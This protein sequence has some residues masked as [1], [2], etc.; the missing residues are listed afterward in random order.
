M[1][2]E[3]VLS[4]GRHDLGAFFAWQPDRDLV[5]RHVRVTPA[6]SRIIPSPRGAEG[7]LSRHRQTHYFAE[8][9]FQVRQFGHTNSF[10]EA[11]RYAVRCRRLRKRRAPWAEP[12]RAAEGSRS[13]WRCEP[14]ADDSHCVLGRDPR[15]SYRLDRGRIHRPSKPSCARTNTQASSASRAG[16]AS[17]HH[18]R[19]PLITRSSGGERR[20]IRR[21]RRGPSTAN[22]KGSAHS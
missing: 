12:R 21:C 10:R 5:A 1:H 17:R 14:D 9:W 13:V 8:L 7:G 3:D 4:G 2:R 22:L 6:W 19:P 20:L 16:L 15:R 18:R 11:I